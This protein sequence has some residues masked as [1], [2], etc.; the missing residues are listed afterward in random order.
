[1]PWCSAIS[2]RQCPTSGSTGSS[3]T[4]HRRPDP[5]AR[6]PAHRAHAPGPPG[7]Y[8][9]PHLMEAFHAFWARAVDIIWDLPLALAVTGCGLYFM[10]ASRFAPF[11]VLGHAIAILRGRYDS[12]RDPGEISHF[13]ALSSALSGTVGLG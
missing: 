5:G 13:Q 8:R 9:R 7:Q 6:F 4:R 3:L 1:S 2:R 12:E 10:I 11:T